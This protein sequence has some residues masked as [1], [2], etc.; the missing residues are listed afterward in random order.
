MDLVFNTD[1][2]APFDKIELRFRFTLGR[3][4]LGPSFSCAGEPAEPEDV[5]AVSATVTVDGARHEAPG[6]L[7]DAF[8]KLFEDDMIEMGREE[9]AQSRNPRYWR[10]A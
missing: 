4:A 7:V 10:A 9:A 8:G 6:W 2:D 5:E 1:W 3:P